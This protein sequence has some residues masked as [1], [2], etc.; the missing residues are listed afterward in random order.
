MC[1]AYEALFHASSFLICR[2][3]TSAFEILT[4]D[5]TGLDLKIMSSKA[6]STAKGAW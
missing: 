3:A 6:L 1:E 5:L 2:G 4:K